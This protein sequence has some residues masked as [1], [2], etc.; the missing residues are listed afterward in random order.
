MSTSTCLPHG[1]QPRTDTVN[2]S[3]P[4]SSSIASTH[5][6]A[7]PPPP[8]S[9]YGLHQI[10]TASHQACS[11]IHIHPAPLLA[12]LLVA[13]GIAAEV[14]QPGFL[15]RVTALGFGSVGAVGAGCV[16]FGVLGWDCGRKS[17]LAEVE[18]IWRVVWRRMGDWVKSGGG[19]ERNEAARAGEEGDGDGDAVSRGLREDEPSLRAYRNTSPPRIIQHKSDVETSQWSTTCRPTPAATRISPPEPATSKTSF[20]YPSLAKSS[21]SKSVISHANP[22]PAPKTTHSS[23]LLGV[24]SSPGITLTPTTTSPQTIASTLTASNEWIHFSGQGIFKRE[25]KSRAVAEWSNP[26]CGRGLEDV[27]RGVEGRDGV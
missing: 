26:G 13:I 25:Q 22:E 27:L 8:H 23:G 6:P 21:C 20:T 17:W 7:T 10:H 12:S 4:P 5:T 9:G 14:E 3:S 1:I 24:S 18:K 15:P 11:Y 19:D 16:V 2:T